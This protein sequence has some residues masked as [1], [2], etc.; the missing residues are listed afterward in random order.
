MNE[1]EQEKKASL[2]ADVMLR[3]ALDLKA[4]DNKLIAE[5]MG[6]DSFKD[7]LASLH[8]GKINVDVDV[9]EQA[10]YHTSWD[11]LIPVVQKIEAEC[12]GVPQE[13]I[14]LSLYS[15]LREVYWAV[16]EFI[17]QINK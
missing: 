11:W 2:H 12:E 9:Y 14:D 6:M 15:N 10:Q 13:L 3:R 4:K 8:Q 17:N 7:S 5:F 1:M 16:V